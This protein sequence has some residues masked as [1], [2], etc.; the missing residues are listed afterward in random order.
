MSWQRF[1]PDILRDLDGQRDARLGLDH[2]DHAASPDAVVKRS[3]AVPGAALIP[4]AA[5]HRNAA[6]KDISRGGGRLGPA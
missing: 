3:S 5:R 6:E 1:V 2:G 4:S